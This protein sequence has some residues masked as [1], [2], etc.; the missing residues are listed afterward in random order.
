[1][2]SFNKGFKVKVLELAYVESRA[3]AS[4]LHQVLKRSLAYW[5]RFGPSQEGE[6]DLQEKISKKTCVIFVG[7]KILFLD[8]M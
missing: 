3:R 7:V 4:R 5:S 8:K 1:M 6:V 2:F